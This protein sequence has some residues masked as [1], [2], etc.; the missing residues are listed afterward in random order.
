LDI[1]TIVKGVEFMEIQT[2]ME[3]TFM[4]HFRSTLSYYCYKSS[5]SFFGRGEGG[6]CLKAIVGHLTIDIK[7]LSYGTY[8]LP[9]LRYQQEH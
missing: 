9:T 8:E 5:N 4:S 1:F 2:Y 7:G 6:N 3:S